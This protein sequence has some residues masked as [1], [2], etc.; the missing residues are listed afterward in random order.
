M[1]STSARLRPDS[2]AERLIAQDAATQRDAM[3]NPDLDENLSERSEGGFP[4]AKLVG[5]LGVVTVERVERVKV[6]VLGGYRSP[7]KPRLCCRKPR[8]CGWS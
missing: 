1:K 6:H 8:D 7:R 2:E 5:K 4:F 3:V